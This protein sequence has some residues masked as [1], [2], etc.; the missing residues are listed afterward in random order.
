MDILTRF[1]KDLK[2][3]KMIVKSDR[4]L[5]A[6]SG[7]K[8]SVCL[9][10]LLHACSKEFGFEIAAC[11]VHHGIRGQEADEDLSFCKFFCKQRD[12][13]F[14][15]EIVDAPGFGKEN[16]LGLEEAGRILR[17]RI[18]EQIAEKEGFN[19]IATA[20]TASDQAETVLFHLVRGSGFYGMSGI[21]QQRGKLIR[22]LLAFYQDEI[23]DFLD[24]L[25]LS[26][27]EDSSNRDTLYSRNRLRGNVIPE[28]KKINPSAEKALVRFANIANEQSELIKFSCNCWENENKIK[29]TSGKVS[30]SAISELAS[31]PEM[32][33]V[34]YEIFS[35]M[36][37]KE[38]IVIDYQ[39]FK[40]LSAL[41]KQPETGKIIEISNGFVFQISSEEL[42]FK[43]NEKK[44]AGIDYQVKLQIGA[45]TLPIP[46]TFIYISDKKQGK[47]ENINKNLLIIHA[48][49]DKI[50]GN[51]FARNRK[52]GDV[53]QIDAMTKKVKK[54]F[55]EAKIPQE[56][57]DR[58]PIVCDDVGIVWIP[59]VGLS[60][61]IRESDRDE[62]FTM[63]IQSSYLP[64]A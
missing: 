33:P 36:A 8:D 16:G 37:S 27:K 3:N 1:Q 50:E 7:G 22:P 24:T 13:P 49:F 62:F 55:Q 40:S 29:A 4:V 11:H 20:H 26:F 5:V 41:L 28:L 39:H 25:H 34:L 19:K 38:K 59:Y 42:V 15:S 35:R 61:R 45:N 32:S 51:L 58:I 47:V 21:P 46:E 2:Q 17:Y 63:T 14:Y 9:L 60:D 44:P 54:L 23:L 52:D 64:E 12:I 56:V 57:R 31:K 43:K 48:A 30:L 53:V 6:F 10:F 18:L